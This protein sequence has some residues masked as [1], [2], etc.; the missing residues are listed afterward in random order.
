M[1]VRHMMKKS[2]TYWLAFLRIFVGLRFLIEGINKVG[3]GWLFGSEEHL[4]S[5]ASS[6]LWSEGTPEFYVNLMKTFVVPNQVFFQKVLVI[7][8]IVTGLALIGGVITI[9]FAILRQFSFF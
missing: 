4:V 2:G 6:Y 9:L 7:T 3:E 5:G 8:E 1:L